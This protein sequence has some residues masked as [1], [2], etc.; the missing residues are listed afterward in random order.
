VLNVVAAEMGLSP[1]IWKVIFG[2]QPMFLS[3]LQKSM[4]MTTGRGNC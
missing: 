4:G 2:P 3:I 1:R